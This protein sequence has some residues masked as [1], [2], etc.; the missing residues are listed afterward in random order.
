MKQQITILNL[1]EKLEKN[2]FKKRIL[3]GG[4]K[5]IKIPDNPCYVEIPDGYDFNTEFDTYIIAFCPDTDSWFV[6]NK[7]FFYYEYDK[8]FETEEDGI[9]F[10]KENPKIFYNEEIRMD[11][12]RPSFRKN[13]VWLD[14]TSSLVE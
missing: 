6:T 8:E 12:Y 13:G 14:N 2:S 3:S 11:V 10:F 5:M 4:K 9:K 1:R 7:R